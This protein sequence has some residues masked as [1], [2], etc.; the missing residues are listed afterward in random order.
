MKLN[1]PVRLY[2]KQEITLADRI[3]E[4]IQNHITLFI[5]LLLMM[6]II[7]FVTLIYAMVGVSA[8]ESG[9]VYN[10]MTRWI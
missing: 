6:M 10:N 1:E 2:K 4:F 8:T 5:M 3:D 7:L 9:A